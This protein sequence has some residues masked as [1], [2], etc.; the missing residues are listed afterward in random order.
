MNEIV[1]AA[2]SLGLTIIGVGIALAT[3]IVKGQNSLKADIEGV[4]TRLKADIAGVETR[5]KADIQ[6]LSDRVDR[7]SVRVDKLYDRINDI[8]KRLCVVEAAV[9]GKFPLRLPEADAKP[10]AK[11]GG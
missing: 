11:A 5:L 7:L 1:I 2:I 9:L 8:D 10:A 6:A 4:E 3:L